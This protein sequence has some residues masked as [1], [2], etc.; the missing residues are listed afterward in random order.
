M[1]KV[2][3]QYGKL[4]D[5]ERFRLAVKA[6]ARDDDG[7]LTALRTT[8]PWAAYN[9]MAPGYVGRVK[10]LARVWSIAYGELMTAAFLCHTFFSGWTTLMRNYDPTAEA[11]DNRPMETM[12]LATREAKHVLEVWRG[13][14]LFTSEVGLEFDE[15]AAFAIAPECRTALELAVSFAEDTV[16]ISTHTLRNAM[17]KWIDGDQVTQETTDVLDAADAD[18]EQ[19]FQERARQ[20]ADTLLELWQR[21]QE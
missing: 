4:D 19:E 17:E 1:N 6:F 12:A 5:H 9:M 21:E 10:G 3:G 2:Q 15:A 16:G 13:L 11:D 18:L 20:Y 14:R 7:E 8:A